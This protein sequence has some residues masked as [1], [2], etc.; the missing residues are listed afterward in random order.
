[1]MTVKEVSRLTGVSVLTLQYYDQIGLLHPGTRTEAGYRLY[2]ATTLETLQQILLF[3]E[4]KFSLKEIA[5][6][7]Q[8]PHCDREKALEQ[9]IELL[10]LQKRHLESLIT[11]AENIR[12]TGGN[13]MDFTAFDTKKLDEY[14]A[15]A[16]QQW[17]A[18]AAYQEY[19][20]KN[21]HETT[22]AQQENARALMALV[23][24]FGHMQTK[25]PADP[26][27]QAQVQKLQAFITEHYY[28]CT[29]EILHSLGQMYREHQRGGRPR[30]GGVRPESHRAILL[31]VSSKLAHC[32]PPR[33]VLVSIAE[34]N[35]GGNQYVQNHAPL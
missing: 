28:T 22:Q 27:V 21:A 13:T 32:I 5:A 35:R 33:F 23:A 3:R 14:A 11:L 16:K 31:R 7:L 19:E 26:A 1:M 12:Q 24:A 20:T 17:G 15:K 10:T 29:K 25:D 6:I 9:Q 8:N 18:T 2:D 30:R 4:L 34:A